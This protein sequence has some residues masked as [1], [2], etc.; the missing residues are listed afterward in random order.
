MRVLFFIGLVLFSIPTLYSQVEIEYYPA[1]EN[2]GLFHVTMI[3]EIP[4]YTANFYNATFPRNE[5][6]IWS[7]D[8][9]RLRKEL[10]IST[11]NDTLD[12]LFLFDFWAEGEEVFLFGYCSHITSG[13]N[14]VYFSKV[15]MSS[16]EIYDLSIVPFED[17][18]LSF[19]HTFGAIH[20]LMNE[21]REWVLL[22]VDKITSDSKALHRFSFHNGTMNW[23]RF[24]TPI[25]LEISRLYDV[26]YDLDNDLL[27]ITA[28]KGHRYIHVF[29]LDFKYLFSQNPISL[30]NG[31]R[32][33]S[34]TKV[35]GNT[36]PTYQ[37]L[38]R[39]RH[40]N[41]FIIHQR[42]MNKVGNELSI[43]EE[44][45]S[46]NVTDD[47]YLLAKYQRDD[48]IMVHYSKS[49]INNFNE[50]YGFDIIYLNPKGEMI[51][52][53]SIEEEEP[54]GVDFLLINE[55]TGIGY[56]SGR[57]TTIGAFERFIFK[58]NLNDTLSNTDG[59]EEG[60]FGSILK[61]N[62]VTDGKLR[63]HEGE[64]ELDQLSIYDVIGR[65]VI[66][67]VDQYEAD[68]SFLPAGHYFLQYR[69]K[70]RMRTERFVK[71]D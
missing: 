16:G 28:T 37:I 3:G 7:F 64:I 71:V 57:W 55:D 31:I 43:S 67:Q 68:I 9:L 22:E 63:I 39:I 25:D 44:F 29:D 62:L 53:F 23:D 46:F 45:V 17:Y 60:V 38:E 34:E 18:K 47:V 5:T 27:I 59:G 40:E 51:K 30:F 33:P 1:P 61:T 6:E 65:E 4:Y 19:G 52:K 8:D 15:D 36:G 50:D 42:N 41:Q 32:R 35:I 20:V 56:G 66:R 21:S 69:A 54:M 2:T 58:I 70:N 49:S 12:H 10:V 14:Y 11:V 24:E 48:L 26:F 13:D